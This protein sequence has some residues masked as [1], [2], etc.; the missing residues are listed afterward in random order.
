MAQFGTVAEPA[1]GYTAAIAKQA[2]DLGFDLLLCPDTQNLAGDPYGQLSLA[3]AATS[4]ILLGTGVTN[5]VTRD[6]AV[7]ASAVASLQVESAGRALCGLGR[8]D[9]SAAHAG[10]ANATLDQLSEY[11]TQVSRYLKGEVVERNE[12][13]SQLRW[14]N[15]DEY[16][17]VPIDIAATGPKTIEMAADI[18]DRV[19][20]AVGS[21]PERIDWAMGV[22]RRRLEQNG[23][24]PA[25][26]QVGA[27]INLVCDPDEKRALNLARMGAGLV[28][29]FT[30]MKGA[31]LD[32]L[33]P[34]LKTI[35]KALRQEYD[36]QHHGRD[37]GSH[38]AL[39]ND[40]FVSWYSICGN[41]QFCVDRLG[42]L[43]EKGLD[44]VYII[45]GSPIPFPIGERMKGLI[46]HQA[47]F[48]DE[49]ISV[50]R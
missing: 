27:F 26:I 29:H 7:T 23:R 5:P 39:I 24:D 37:E 19:S 44:H 46:E 3:A 42:A 4:K 17:C 9:S 50:L 43:I 30:A 47:L 1:P 48:A 28:A 10:K 38:L 45:G 33:P 11:A 40:D 21:A 15:A 13:Q 18:A 8:G 20:F 36:M 6:A 32:H 12:T 25:D 22:L 35:A 14:F 41:P 31:S 49:V 2:E 34:Q 16:A